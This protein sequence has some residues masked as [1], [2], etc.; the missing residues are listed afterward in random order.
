MSNPLPAGTETA[1]A[2]VVVAAGRSALTKARAVTLAGVAPVPGP[3][4]T[5]LG[6]AASSFTNSIAA[7]RL[8]SLLVTP[9]VGIN[10]PPLS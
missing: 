4:R 9:P 10:V 1:P 3:A 5:V 8:T 6:E 2:V 7:K